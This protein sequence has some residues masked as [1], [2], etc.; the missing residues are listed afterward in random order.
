MQPQPFGYGYA[1]APMPYMNYM[2]FQPVAYYAY[3]QSYMPAPMAPQPPIIVNLPQNMQQQP[4]QISQPYIQKY[5]NNPINSYIAA[6]NVPTISQ[7]FTNIGSNQVFTQGYNPSQ[8]NTINQIFPSN[9][10][11]NQSFSPFN[12]GNNP[13]GGQ[14][15]TGGYPQHQNGR[16]W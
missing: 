12:S 16:Q 7:P 2:P 11:S 13:F 14:N 10:I 1:P 3:G 6:S 15:P 4:S 9:N 8:I 5:Q